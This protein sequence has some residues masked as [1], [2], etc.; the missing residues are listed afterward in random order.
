MTDA[1]VPADPGNSAPE[2]WSEPLSPEEQQEANDRLGQ[3]AA[4]R[5][6]AKNPEEGR[7]Q[8]DYEVV[9][10]QVLPIDKS[11]RTTSSPVGRDE[12]SVEPAQVE[13]R[14][15]EDVARDAEPVEQPVDQPAEEDVDGSSSS[16]N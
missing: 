1:N 4:E 7:A 6:N 3:H 5:E 14:N 12:A 16:G 13:Y 8:A 11:S 15:D 10:G 9:D 2:A